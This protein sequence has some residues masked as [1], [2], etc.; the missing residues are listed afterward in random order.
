MATPGA[1]RDQKSSKCIRCFLSELPILNTCWQHCGLPPQ[2]F[3]AKQLPRKSKWPTDMFFTKPYRINIHNAWYRCIYKYFIYI[4]PHFVCCKD[5]TYQNHPM[6]PHPFEIF[7]AKL[8]WTPPEGHESCNLLGNLCVV[9]QSC[10]LYAWEGGGEVKRP[11]FLLE[12]WWWRG[13]EDFSIK[14]QREDQQERRS[15]FFTHLIMIT[16]NGSL[17]METICF[18]RSRVYYTQCADFIIFYMVFT[19]YIILHQ[20]LL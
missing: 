18:L 20:H 14:K 5:S 4:Y 15:F 12:G 9:C 19:M 17:K 16:W 3:S 11:W 13:G 7:L 6:D 8:L 2:K 10:R 1:S